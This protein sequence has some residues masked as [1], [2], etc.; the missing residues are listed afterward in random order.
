[1]SICCY[2]RAVNL[3]ANHIHLIN[4]CQVLPIIS[5]FLEVMF[6]GFYILTGFLQNDS[7]EKHFGVCGLMS[8]CNYSIQSVLS[9]SPPVGKWPKVD[10]LRTLTIIDL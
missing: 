10:Y 7:L 2:S 8:G 6:L 4:T 5:T 3:T 9:N 1:M